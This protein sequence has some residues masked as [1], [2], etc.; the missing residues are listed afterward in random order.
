MTLALTTSPGAVGLASGR[1]VGVMVVEDIE[2]LFGGGLPARRLNAK[3][4]AHA[5]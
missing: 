2:T 1:N 4:L 3:E 5:L